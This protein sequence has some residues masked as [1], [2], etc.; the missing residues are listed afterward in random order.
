VDDT[1]TGTHPTSWDD[2]KLRDG[3]PLNIYQ[4]ILRYLRDVRRPSITSARDLCFVITSFC[5]AAFD[6]LGTTEDF[7]FFDFM[8][9]SIGD[10]VSGPQHLVSTA[11]TASERP[12]SRSS[13]R[14]PGVA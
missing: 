2:F 6:P 14:V 4:A 8:E 11:L 3:D 1:T 9:R 10:V 13:A 12:N 5:L 7:H